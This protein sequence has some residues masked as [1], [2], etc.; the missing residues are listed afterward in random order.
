MPVCK[1]CKCTVKKVIPHATTGIKLCLQC[2]TENG[3]FHL[4]KKDLIDINER[5]DHVRV[6]LSI[7]MEFSLKDKPHDL[8]HF[9]AYTIDLS[10]SG[11]SFAWDACSHSKHEDSYTVDTGC[12]LYPYWIDHTSPEELILDVHIG[13]SLI[14]S[15]ASHVIYTASDPDTGMEYVGVR[16]LHVNPQTRRF[17]EKT[18]FKQP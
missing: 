3:I 14:V 13:S 16:F 12:L 18:I 5:R 4:H 6:P 10:L 8:R 15:I 17:L 11:L 7:V 9:P 2:I 1:Q